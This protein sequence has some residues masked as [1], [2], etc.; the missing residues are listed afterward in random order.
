MQPG[1]LYFAILCNILKEKKKWG[2]GG[3]LVPRLISSMRKSLGTRLG[4]SFVHMCCMCDVHVCDG[5]VCDGCVCDG[6]V[7]CV[8]DVCV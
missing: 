1:L 8:C 2:G 7:M 6:C 4:V 3:S 5:C